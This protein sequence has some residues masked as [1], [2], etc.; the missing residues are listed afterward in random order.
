MLI[1]AWMGPATQQWQNDSSGPIAG[2]ICHLE[3]AACR[4][5]TVSI[6]VSWGREAMGY[7]ARD[8]KAVECS[9][10]SPSSCLRGNGC[11]EGECYGACMYLDDIL[12]IELID[13]G[14]KNRGEFWRYLCWQSVLRM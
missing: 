14:C 8:R 10:M 7:G 3:A 11:A 5:G 9:D 1:M 6:S 12:N 4:R 2:Q 13:G